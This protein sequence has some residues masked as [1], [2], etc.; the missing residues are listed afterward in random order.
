MEEISTKAENCGTA[1]FGGALRVKRTQH[2]E[3]TIDRP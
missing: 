1:I 3:L 2:S